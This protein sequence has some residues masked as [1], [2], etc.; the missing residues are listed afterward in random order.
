MRSTTAR[1]RSPRSLQQMQALL[2]E[3]SSASARTSRATRPLSTSTAPNSLTTTAIFLP[4]TPRSRWFRVVVLPLP[5]KPTSTP[6]GVGARPSG[7]RRPLPAPP[8]RP[9]PGVSQVSPRPLSSPRPG[10]GPP[11]T[12]APGHR[13]RA[14]G[15]APPANRSPHLLT[16]VHHRGAPGDR[17][18]PRRPLCYTPQSLIGILPSS[19]KAG[20]AR[21]AGD[22]GERARRD[23]GDA[24]RIGG[25][26]DQPAHRRAGGARRGRSPGGVR[27]PPGGAERR[28]GRAQ[29]HHLRAVHQPRSGR[30]LL[31]RVP[32]QR[33]PGR[34]PA[35]HH[36]PA[37]TWWPTSPGRSSGRTR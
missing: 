20:R 37:G 32:A 19:Y 9:P 33:R 21:P 13:G 14:T 17:P 31:A 36:A 15:G 7:R 23:A 12:P 10:R 6:T 3:I 2:S 27:A 1:S 24:A 11:R 35:A 18:G 25:R 16:M 28:G 4:W 22:G 8:S 29:D 34:D 26:A 30:R 5:R